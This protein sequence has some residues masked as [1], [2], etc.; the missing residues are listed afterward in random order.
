MVGFR[1]LGDMRH[2]D[3]IE[4]HARVKEY[5]EG[6]RGHRVDWDM[7]HKPIEIDYNDL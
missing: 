2:R 3:L 6:Y 7:D 1:D 4:F 5:K